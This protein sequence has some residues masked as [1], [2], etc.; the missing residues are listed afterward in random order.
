MGELVQEWLFDAEG[1]YV[2]PACGEKFDT[3]EECEAH[4]QWLRDNFK[5]IE[6]H[7]A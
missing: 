3:P 4:E 6:S 1:R 2:C 7:D 5:T